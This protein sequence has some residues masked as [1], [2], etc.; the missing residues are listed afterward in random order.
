MNDSFLG[1]ASLES[2]GGWGIV[3]V[4][5]SGRVAEVA[6]HRTRGAPHA[7]RVGRLA[8]SSPSCHASILH[9][10]CE[11]RDESEECMCGLKSIVFLAVHIQMNRQQSHN[12]ILGSNYSKN[13]PLPANKGTL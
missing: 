9:T 2:R 12:I 5:C 13:P 1:V 4:L 7:V 11:D 10:C 3:C 6:I 8:D